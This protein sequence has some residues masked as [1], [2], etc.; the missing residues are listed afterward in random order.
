MSIIIVSD[1]DCGC[2]SK[3]LNMVGKVDSYFCSLFCFVMM[4]ACREKNISSS[5]EPVNGSTTI[6]RFAVLTGTF[7]SFRSF[8]FAKGV[9]GCKYMQKLLKARPSAMIAVIAQVKAKF[10][11]WYNP[12]IPCN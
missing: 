5:L 4:V 6:L 2:V 1:F 7:S 10:N 3:V 9:A 12:T 8:R 11:N